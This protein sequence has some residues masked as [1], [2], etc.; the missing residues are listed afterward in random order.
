MIFTQ[1]NFIKADWKTERLTVHSSFWWS[2]A[3]KAKTN[4]AKTCG[5]MAGSFRPVPAPPQKKF[6]IRFLVC[7][8]F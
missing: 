6:L 3:Q 7:S 5:Q 2:E 1:T 8:N 4:G